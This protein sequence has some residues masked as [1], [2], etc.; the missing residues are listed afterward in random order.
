VID[1]SYLPFLFL[2][3]RQKIIRE[4][5]SDNPLGDIRLEKLISPD[6]I[7]KKNTPRE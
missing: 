5:K 4:R 1:K 3:K 6:P 2:N 7:I